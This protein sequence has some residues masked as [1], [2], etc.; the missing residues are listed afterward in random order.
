MDTT[1]SFE[2][3]AARVSERFRWQWDEILIAGEPFRLAVASDPEGMLIEACERQDA[4]EQGVIDPFW[5]T[6]WR[7]AA[8][9]D[10]FLEQVKLKQVSVLELGCGTGHAGIAAIRRG[11]NVTLT[12]GV[13]DPLMLVRMSVWD[14]R[15]RCQ[16]ERLRFGIDRIAGPSF[17]II[18]GSDV[19]YL[20]SLW[21]ELD[22]CLRDHLAQA[23]Q[24]FL[25]DPYRIIANEFRGW[26]QDKGWHYTEHR[27]EMEDDPEH[28]IRVMELRAGGE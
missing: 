25:S 19:T 18:L 22:H 13:D 10:R 3:L 24:V 6:T 28:P 17:P 4:G 14:F 7:A 12:D 11:A 27:V 26:I 9:L 20:R 23:G 21:P 16:V 5:A 1:E 8:G 2:Q 15:D